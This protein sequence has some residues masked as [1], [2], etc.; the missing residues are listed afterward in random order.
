VFLATMFV[1]IRGMVIFLT[2]E[3]IG[4]VVGWE[5]IRL[6]SFLLIGF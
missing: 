3:M 2:G 1:F 6:I 5:G 4:I